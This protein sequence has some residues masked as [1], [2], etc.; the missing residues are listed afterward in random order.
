M[1]TFTMSAESLFSATSK[2]TL[3]L[4]LGSKKRLTTVLP[5]NAGTFLIERVAIWEKALAVSRMMVISSAV[6]FSNP[7]RSFLVHGIY[8]P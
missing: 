6:S 1:L 7:K 4:V 5:C 3:V 8:A 2:D